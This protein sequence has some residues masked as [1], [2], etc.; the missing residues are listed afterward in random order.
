MLAFGLPLVPT[1]LA[2]WALML[3]DRLM[4]G[5][6][7][8]LDDVGQYAAANRV[9]AVL[10]LGVT[11]FATAFGPYALSLY[12]EDRELEKR[13]RA[14]ALTYLTAALTLGALVLALFARELLA[15]LAPG[16]DRAYQAVGLVALGAV[17]FGV[18]SVAM[19]GI[20]F[21]RRTGWFAV[22]TLG[23]AA[24]NIGLNLILIPAFGMIG[25]A[26]ATAIAFAALA[27]GHYVVSQR[28]YPTPY[29]PVRMVGIVALG[30]VLAPL[31]LVDVDREGVELL[32]KLAAV[33]A[34]LVSMRAVGVVRAGQL[35]AAIR[36]LAPSRE[37]QA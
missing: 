4:L 19:A 27:A 11:A 21:A 2:M 9:V 3:V 31:G 10:L 35:R 17:S 5:R 20:S 36:G 28:L 37:A 23:A 34:F 14:R 16:Y 1:A 29:D 6:L 26:A 24:L 32:V 25:A 7:A 15:L 8:G 30:A 22:L 18:S 12:S 33:A 13:V